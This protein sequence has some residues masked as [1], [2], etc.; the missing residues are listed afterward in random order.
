MNFQDRPDSGLVHSSRG[1]LLKCFSHLCSSK[2]RSASAPESLSPPGSQFGEAHPIP[3]IPLVLVRSS[4]DPRFDHSA[5]Q[6]TSLASASNA[7][8]MR[9]WDTAELIRTDRAFL[10]RI[11]HD[12]ELK[13]DDPTILELKQIIHRRI[14]ALDSEFVSAD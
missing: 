10:D 9:S 3:L 8:T 7:I 12:S 13:Q 14:A 11:E 1:F 2:A 6:P 5:E 4:A